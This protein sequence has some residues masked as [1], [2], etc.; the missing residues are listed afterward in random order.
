VADDLDKKYNARY[1]IENLNLKKH[2]EGGY[3]SQTFK[4]EL[5]LDGSFVANIN[6]SRPLFTLIYFLL[7]HDQFSALHRLKSDEIWHFYFGSSLTLY[8]F[9]PTGTLEKKFLGSDFDSNQSFQQLVRAGQWFGADID[10]KN[11]YS[12]VGCT[13]SP[14]FDFDD[15]EMGEREK[16]LI[17]YPQHKNLIERLTRC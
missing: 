3:Y 2:P 1:W 9:S 14:G 8:I 13:V 5:I 12:L 11:S 16:L 17:V 4:S 7:D 6:N 10:D 15:F